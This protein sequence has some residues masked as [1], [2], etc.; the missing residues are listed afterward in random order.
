MT[1]EAQ[2]IAARYKLR[3]HPVLGLWWDVQ[4]KFP[5]R[6]RQKMNGWLPFFGKMF[7]VRFD[8]NCLEWKIERV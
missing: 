8:I 4:G 7:F 3:Q 5:W 6:L 1:T 2:D